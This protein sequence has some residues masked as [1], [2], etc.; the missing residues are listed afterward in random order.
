MSTKE[1]CPSE[2]TSSIISNRIKWNRLTSGSLR[3]HLSKDFGS[4]KKCYPS[5]RTDYVNDEG[6]CVLHYAYG[7]PS[8]NSRW[9]G[10]L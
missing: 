5:E 6:I 8:G 7:K 10:F 2:K 3:Q 4:T 9:P 1:S